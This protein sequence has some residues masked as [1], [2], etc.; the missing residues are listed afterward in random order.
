MK[1]I[2][3]SY[4]LSFHVIVTSSQLIPVYRSGMTLKVIKFGTWFF[5][6][7]NVALN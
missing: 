4:L 2:L 1:N 5:W 3:L 6:V 7:N